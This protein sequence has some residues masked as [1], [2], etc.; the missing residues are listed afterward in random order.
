[1]NFR[2]MTHNRSKSV[3]DMNAP[4]NIWMHDLLILNHIWWFNFF[5][6][7]VFFFLFYIRPK[8]KHLEQELKFMCVLRFSE[9]NRCSTR[10]RWIVLSPVFI[11]LQEALNPR[12]NWFLRLRGS[13]LILPLVR[14]VINFWLVNQVTCHR[15]VI[16]SHF[17]A[18]VSIIHLLHS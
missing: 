8:L 11:M 6:Q 12:W 18:K 14:T 4:S 10:V 2:S 16:V 1:M 17:R 15:S 9:H 5:C 7:S 13:S 3:H